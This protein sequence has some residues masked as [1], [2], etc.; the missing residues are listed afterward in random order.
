MKRWHT[1]AIGLIVS[2]VALYL[3]F[4][5][6]NFAEI[7]QGFRSARYEYVALGFVLVG[8]T[9]LARGLRWS[10]LTEGRLSVADA[11]WL[12]NMG[13]L[14]NNVLPARLGEIVRAMLAGRRPQMRFTS[15]LSS[16]VVERLF[17][18][19]SVV[20]LIGI[21]L[22][23]LNLPTWATSA[24]AMMGVGAGIGIAV[25]ALAARY[26]HGSLQIG[27]R[28]LALLPRMD[29]AR[30]LAFLRPFVEGLGAV[31]NL[32]TFAAGLSL[33]V[34]AWLLS[35]ITGWALMLALWPHMPVM[36][37]MLAIA[38][39]GLGVA[40]PAAPAGVGPFEAAV[41]GVLT[42]S[43]YDA[44]ISRSYA[45]GIHFITFTTT[46]LLGA[47]GLLRE[48]MSFSEVAR[49]AE[50]LSGQHTVGPAPPLETPPE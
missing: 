26:P 40:I 17:D 28:V 49:A 1:F 25:L 47:L 12:F 14:F 5:Q 46:S 16:I 36:M 38:A 21:T 27:A 35:G 33:S 29:E 11:T 15:A 4:R 24:G 44:D 34:A 37:G 32:R 9:T 10:V 43:G 3:A 41:I 30:A 42:A 48:G 45:I 39:A 22:M 13:F 6:A 31:S 2:V 23:S 18:M 50:A 20:V 7:L 8:L 19:I